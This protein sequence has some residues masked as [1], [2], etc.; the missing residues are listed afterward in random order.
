MLLS[1]YRNVCGI[2]RKISDDIRRVVRTAVIYEQNFGLAGTKGL[3]RKR[4]KT[5][6]NCTFRIIKRHDNRYNLFKFGHKITSNQ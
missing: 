4:V 6:F 2:N 3:S 5:L 1:Y